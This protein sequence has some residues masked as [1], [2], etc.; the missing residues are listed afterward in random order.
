[1]SANRAHE[2]PM[3]ANAL[4]GKGEA[5]RGSS[6]P[7]GDEV[8]PGEGTLGPVPLPLPRDP[9]VRAELLVRLDRGIAES[10]TGCG[11]DW[12]ALD[13]RPRAKYGLP[14]ASRS[15]SRSQPPSMMTR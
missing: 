11:V 1:M 6:I 7:A 14:P 13:R 2:H 5:P 9:T 8:E 3:M 15:G 4:D 12:E 10:R